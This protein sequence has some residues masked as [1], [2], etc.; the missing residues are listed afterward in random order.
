MSRQKT[1]VRSGRV[2][3][4][5]RERSAS[6]SPLATALIA[7]ASPSPTPTRLLAKKF[8]VAISAGAG[9]GGVVP[10]RNQRE[11]LRNREAPVFLYLSVAVPGFPVF[12]ARL[13]CVC[14]RAH[15]RVCARGGK[16]GTWE[17]DNNILSF[18]G[19]SGSLT[20]SRW[21][22]LGTAVVA[23]REI[24]PGQAGSNILGGGNPARSVEQAVIGVR[25]TPNA[26]RAAKTFRDFAWSRGS[27]GA[28]GT[29]ELGRQLVDQGEERNGG[30]QPFAAHGWARVG[31]AMLEGMARGGASARFG[32]RQRQPVRLARS[33]DR[34]AWRDRQ[35]TPQCPHSRIPDPLSCGRSTVSGFGTAF[36]PTF[37]HR[38]AISAQAKGKGN[39]AKVEACPTGR[40]EGERRTSA[41]LAAAGRGVA[42]VDRLVAGYPALRR[43]CN[44]SGRRA[45]VN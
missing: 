24:E 26:G 1:R 34:R 20:G 12:G 44:A 38:E 15:M 13:M 25:S 22:P 39:L 4:A 5:V 35:R 43:G 40:G 16:Q 23:L 41:A 45:G 19:V 42:P 3:D 2:A 7:S 17:P 18:E 28:I 6:F 11:P 33:A 27:A 36:R 37:G 14:A 30:I 8:V 31:T 21:F 32:G 10:G 9:S 29:L